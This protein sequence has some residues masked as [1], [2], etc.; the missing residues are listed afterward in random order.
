MSAVL[1]TLAVLKRRSADR[2]RSAATFYRPVNLYIPK[3]YSFLTLLEQVIPRIKKFGK[4]ERTALMLITFKFYKFG[5]EESGAR[6]AMLSL[7][8]SVCL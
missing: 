2:S 8:L 1:Y 4:G 7:S 5:P 6:D 3:V